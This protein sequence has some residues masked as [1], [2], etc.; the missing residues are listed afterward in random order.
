[1]G[2]LARTLE[3]EDVVTACAFNPESRTC[4][5][6][7][8]GF[9]VRRWDVATGR[10][11]GEQMALTGAIS[12]LA[13]SRD[14]RWMLAGTRGDL[15]A[16]LG[17]LMTNQLGGPLLPHRDDISALAISDDSKLLLTASLDGTAR[18]WDAE[19]GKALGPSFRH[20]GQVKAVLFCP[21]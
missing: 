17:D 16:R 4:A 6:G 2:K 13:L 21:D 8:N 19:T 3:H 14:G 11:L 1:T 7:T 12:A 10:P 18:L 9:R 15:S 5:T 20:N